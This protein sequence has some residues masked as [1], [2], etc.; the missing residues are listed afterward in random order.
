MSLT[1]K[2][3]NEL[4]ELNRGVS[5]SITYH[6]GE[7]DSHAVSFADLH[8]RALGIL[9]HLQQLG[10][11]PGDK[12]ILF[13]A[14]NEQFIDVFWAAVLGGIVPV[15]VAI[16]ISDEHRH[17]LLRIARKLGKPFLVHRSPQPRPHRSLRDR[18]RR[19]REL[20]AASRHARS[21]SRTC[22]TSASPAHRTPRNPKTPRSSSSPPVPPAS[23]RAWC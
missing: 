14:S 23:R 3:L 9:W 15:P 20:S 10:A 11:R 12:L 13:L 7:N 2:T 1:A 16:G 21:S 22:R 17:K 8:K 5:R 19:R 18:E 4:M 6:A